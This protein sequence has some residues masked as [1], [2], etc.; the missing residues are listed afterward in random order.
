MRIRV[1]FMSGVFTWSVCEY[2]M[3]SSIY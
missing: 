2:E 3:V 1:E